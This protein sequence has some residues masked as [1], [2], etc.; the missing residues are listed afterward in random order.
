MS[1]I[2]ETIIFNRTVDK[3]TEDTLTKRIPFNCYI[4]KTEYFFAR[5]QQNLLHVDVKVKDVSVAKYEKD[6]NKYVMGDGFS[7]VVNSFF[8]VKAEAELECW[9]ENIDADDTKTLFVIVHLFRKLA[10]DEEPPKE[11]KW[12]F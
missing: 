3:S 6:S 10:K 5:N 12:W 9:Y 1:E 4:V 11:F 8:E 7:V 2:T